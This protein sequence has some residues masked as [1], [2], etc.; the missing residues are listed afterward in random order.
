VR[1]L[2][3]TNV[4]LW[5]MNEPEKLSAKARNGCEDPENEIILSVVTAWEIQIKVQIGKLQLDDPLPDIIERQRTRNNARLLPIELKHVL[6]LGD[7]ERH[8]G[9]PFDRL[10]IAQAR[11]E[12]AHLVTNDPAIAKYPVKILW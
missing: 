3:D 7:L 1:I 8:H 5:L 11:V 6:A 4:F 9:D 10:L 12:D 2:L